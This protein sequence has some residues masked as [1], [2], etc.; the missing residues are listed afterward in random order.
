MRGKFSARLDA[1]NGAQLTVDTPIEITYVLNISTDA[2][3]VDS[4]A[5]TTELVLEELS[6]DGQL[7]LIAEG[8][9]TLLLNADLWVESNK[10]GP[11]I[12]ANYNPNRVKLN[13]SYTLEELVAVFG[14]HKNTV[15]SWVENGL[16]CLKE[17][18]PFLILG[19]EAR[20]YLQKWRTVKK[21][22]CKPDELFCMRCK[23]PK[24]AAENY[25]E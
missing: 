24:I 4:V 5:P 15:S 9:S 2:M 6:V 16:P 10:A 19:V 1:I 23:T 8:G 22:Q 18:R 11:T 7:E 25:V 14:V 17:R 13:R 12:M 3:E 21:Q 20:I